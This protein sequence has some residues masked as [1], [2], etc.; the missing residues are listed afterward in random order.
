MGIT[1][2]KKDG[3][4]WYQHPVYTW[5]WLAEDKPFPLVFNSKKAPGPGQNTYTDVGEPIREIKGRIIH[6]RCYSVK[7]ISTSHK[8][9]NYC[10]D[11]EVILKEAQE[12]ASKRALFRGSKWD[13]QGHYNCSSTDKSALDFISSITDF[14]TDA[15]TEPL[16]DDGYELWDSSEVPLPHFYQPPHHTIDYTKLHKHASGLYSA[17]VSGQLVGATPMA[18]E[19]YQ[20]YLLKTQQK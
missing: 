12:G 11:A 13:P 8:G 6:Y 1:T 3:K 7:M 17:I 4:T 20:W 18:E 10:V 16:R 15:P 5:L 2:C 14:R 19:A 9:L